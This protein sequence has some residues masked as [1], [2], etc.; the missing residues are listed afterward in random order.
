MSKTERRERRDRSREWEDSAANLPLTSML[1]MI[2]ILLIFVMVSVQFTPVGLL[3]LELPGVGH[4]D[5]GRESALRIAV[6][7][8]GVIRFNGKEISLVDFERQIPRFDPAGKGV[9]IYADRQAP[10]G[11]FAQILAI[12]RQENCYRIQIVTERRGE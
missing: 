8:E 5:R 11:I 9:R 12:L 1:D 10:F 2:F 3:D 6:N 7:R 4:Q